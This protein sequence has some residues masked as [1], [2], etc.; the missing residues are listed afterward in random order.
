MSVRKPAFTVEI[1]KKHFQEEKLDGLIRTFIKE[2]RGFPVGVAF[3]V[4]LIDKYREEVKI[5]ILIW[6]TIDKERVLVF[7]GD[8]DIFDISYFNREGEKIS[9]ADLIF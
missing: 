2:T 9:R 7:L 8:D 1:N 5:G 4:V 6:A 3:E